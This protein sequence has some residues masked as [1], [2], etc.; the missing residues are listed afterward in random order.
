M[1]GASSM[2]GPGKPSAAIPPPA[3]DQEDALF[4]SLLRKLPASPDRAHL[5]EA[6]QA[7]LRMLLHRPG[8][9][10]TLDAMCRRAESIVR[11]LPETPAGDKARADLMHGAWRCV[12]LLQQAR[13]PLKGQPL[14]HTDPADDSQPASGGRP[15]RA[16]KPKRRR[17]REWILAVGALGLASGIGVWALRSG[18]GGE[19]QSAAQ[20]ARQMEE[21]AAG[22]PVA[23]H[24][25]GG[26]L[27]VERDGGAIV[28]VAERVPSHACVST[29]WTLIRKGVVSI[30]GETPQRV[31]AAILSSLCRDSPEGATLSWQPR[32]AE[33]R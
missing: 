14:S 30:N 3:Q 6:T 13:R 33:Q 19:P 16:A 31:S 29:G 11:T 22:T 15:R 32:T 4:Q 27:R 23:V 7:G 1:A 18:G 17:T 2:N 5:L 21:A 8:D 10:D 9:K 25:F 12:E 20:L 26:P 28:V 24:A